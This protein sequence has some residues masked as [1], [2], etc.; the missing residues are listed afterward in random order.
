MLRF[1][2]SYTEVGC[3]GGSSTGDGTRVAERNDPADHATGFIWTDGTVTDYMD[4][5][6]GEPN[7][8]TGSAANCDPTSETP[9]SK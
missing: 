4:W 9:A 3:V 2:D 6:N 8:W 5:S 1:H 7:D